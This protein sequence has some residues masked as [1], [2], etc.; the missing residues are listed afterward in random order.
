MNEPTAPTVTPRVPRV[1]DREQSFARAR[2]M[3]AMVE[4]IAT[5]GYESACMENV[6]RRTGVDEVAFHEHFKDSEACRVAAL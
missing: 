5:E 4:I 3:S 6:C 2:L 1:N